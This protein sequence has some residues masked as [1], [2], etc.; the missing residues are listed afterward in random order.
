MDQFEENAGVFDEDTP[1]E[2]TSMVDPKKYRTAQIAVQEIKRVF[3]DAIKKSFGDGADAVYKAKWTGKLNEDISFS[4]ILTPDRWMWFDAISV[5][6][7]IKVLP[8]DYAIF[9]GVN[10]DGNAEIEFVFPAIRIV[11]KK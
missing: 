5:Y 1:G 6:N 9:T 4:V 7:I 3:S 2:F 8:D 11:E 10:E